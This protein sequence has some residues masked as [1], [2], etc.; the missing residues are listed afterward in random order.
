MVTFLLIIIYTAYVGLGIPDSLF[1]AAWP[2]IYPEFNIGIEDANFVTVILYAGTTVSSLFSAKMVK[3]FGTSRITAISTAATAIALL[4]FSM[5]HS[6]GML[7]VCAIPLGLGAGAIDSALNNYVA[8]NYKASHMSFLHCCYGIGISL[9]PFLMAEAMVAG[10]GWRGGYEIMFY[11]QAAIAVL[12]IATLPVWK[13]AK[14][15]NSDICDAPMKALSIKETFSLPGVKQMA[16]VF[17]SSCAI[18]STCGIWGSSFLVNSKGLPV[19]EGALMITLYYIGIAA[20]RGLSGLL[21]KKLTPIKIVYLGFFMLGAAFALMILPLPTMFAAAGLFLIG[22]G[23]GPLYPNLM[24]LMPKYYGTE[25]SQSVIGLETAFS[26]A[27]FLTMPILFGVIAG[28][29]GT[30]LFPVYLA[31]FFALLLIGLFTANKIY[32]KQGVF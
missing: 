13:K 29:I 14:L 24:H 21:S 2:A 32:K 9:S 26:N 17:F 28:S 8:I 19:H 25:V 7:C 15:A 5:S 3:K 23:N 12:T 31:V 10:G 4:G 6:L 18:E 11:V 1:G 20:G 16:V 27:A 30:D 22:F